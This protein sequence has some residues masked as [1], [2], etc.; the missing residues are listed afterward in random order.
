MKK[1]LKYKIVTGNNKRIINKGFVSYIAA[2]EWILIRDCGQYKSE[3]GWYIFPY[4]G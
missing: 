4:M 3:G 2:R 1:T